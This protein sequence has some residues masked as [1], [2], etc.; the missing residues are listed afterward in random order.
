M[1]GVEITFWIEAFNACHY[2]VSGGLIR[3]E[4]PNGRNYMEQENVVVEMFHII[5]EQAVEVMKS[6]RKRN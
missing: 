4:W 5:Y 6:A 2:P 1:A 3:T